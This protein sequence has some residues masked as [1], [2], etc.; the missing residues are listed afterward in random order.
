[1]KF[2]TKVNAVR[3]AMEFSHGIRRA[4]VLS[5]A[6]VYFLHIGLN[7]L[8][9]T[10]LFAISGIFSLL[11]EFPTGA[12]A[13]YDSRKKSLMISFFLFA[14]AFL[15]IYFSY[16]FW[17]IAIFWILSE[18][19]WTFS[20][21]AGSAWAID[22]LNIG[23]KKK[24]I[25]K[26]I[27][28]SYIFEKI[29]WI[30]GGLLGLVIIAINFRLIW[31]V[32][33]L[34][35]LVMFFI[36]WKYMEERNFKPEKVPHNY[37]KKSWIKAIESYHFL[38]HKK[39]RNLRILMITNILANI[40]YAMFY[41]AI[42][43]LFVQILKLNPEF[44]SGLLAGLALLALGGPIL[45]EKFLDKKGFKKSLFNI[46]IIIGIVIIIIAFSKSLIIAFL[47][48]ALYEI[49]GTA[50]DILDESASHY[51]FDS[52]IRASLGSIGSIN[53]RVS[54]SIGVFI[55]GIIISIFGIISTLVISG[56]MVLL[57]AFI[58]LFLR[59]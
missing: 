21:G 7:L 45:A 34:I 51:E 37:L 8:W 49:L 30:V 31:L 17:P 48:F 35:G 13:D 27:S 46:S 24:Q 38:I 39:N 25:V 36:L 29:G 9:I 6:L 28:S 55:A 10:T 14:I 44:Y 19:A 26:L 12:V 42:P 32:S 43:L 53:N 54:T 40:G 18:L 52:K 5:L 59:D 56:C 57:T 33:G 23:E 1:M 20:T 58:Y 3:N 16:S 11:F 4:L 15:G 50:L 47:L 22:A 41:L 2:S